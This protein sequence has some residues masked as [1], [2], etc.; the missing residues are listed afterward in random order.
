[1]VKNRWELEIFDAGH[2]Q[3]DITKHFAAFCCLYVNSL[4]KKGKNTY[5]SSKMP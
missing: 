3:Y 5:Y 4:P 1:M 2:A